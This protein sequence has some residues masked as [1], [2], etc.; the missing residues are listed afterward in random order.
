M[1]DKEQIKA[2]IK[3]VDNYEDAVALCRSIDVLSLDTMVARKLLRTMRKFRAEEETG[4]K[5]VVRI[6]YLGNITFEPMPDYVEI[7]AACRGLE[8]STYIGGY[9][10]YMQELINDSSA[11]S[12]F[13]PQVI[14]INLTLRELVPE[15]VNR[16]SS[17]SADEIEAAKQQIL[18]KA[19]STVQLALERYQA[20]VIVSN[21]PVPG[22]FQLGIADQKHIC[23]ESVF[24]SELNVEI[25][26]R[27][28]DKP[29][30]MVFDM[31]RL[32]SLYGRLNAY[33]EK[34]YY[35]AKVPWQEEFY[36]VIADQLIRHVSAA[37]GRTKK[38]LVL[39]LDNTLWGG[40][41]GEAGIHGVKVG[42]GD[43]ESE[44]FY[45]FQNRIR[46][47]K[48]R[49]IILAVCSKNNPGDVE[50]MFAQR[51]GMPLKMADFSAT[52]VSWDMKHQGISRIAEKLNIGLDSIVFVDDNPAECEL[53]WQMLPQVETILLPDD[54]SVYPALLDS[55]FGFDKMQV[56]AE[57]Q[58]KAKQYAEGES[59]VKH[60]AGFDDLESYLESL[61]TEISIVQAG[62][63]Q[64]MR[65]HQLFSKTNQF[66]VTT[67]RYSMAEVESFIEG[68]GFDIY[69]VQ[70]NDRFGDLGIIGL[71]L[72]DN[73]SEHKVFI[74]SFILSCRA[75]GRGIETAVMNFLKEEY[76]GRR[77]MR[78]IESM[79]VPTRKNMPARNFYI[80]QGFEAVTGDSEEASSYT[81]LTD[82]SS[83]LNCHWI[84]TNE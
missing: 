36:L 30:A 19:V 52:E 53:I 62:E 61:G 59:R 6:A 40:V 33:D 67:K 51:T 69:T 45:D 20:T 1:K 66:N 72:V 24:Y 5:D 71:C 8:T 82:N 70:A 65:V 4:G 74:D 47:L 18:D 77:N 78:S 44:A 9:D 34:M 28:R 81:L 31:D 80:D 64:K 17:L 49:G 37:A 13:S 41:L 25:S 15:I 56:T 79:F 57:D 12:A 76:F 43:G 63:Q 42:H 27:L 38:C 83:I 55:F 60:Q 35:L 75:M 26:R 10:Q 39:D 68:D 11:L 7:V 29:R 2:A 16:Y 32:V 48:D 14:F 58:E 84:K 21:F 50:E 3:S 73:S 22:N 46:S 23:P 54:P